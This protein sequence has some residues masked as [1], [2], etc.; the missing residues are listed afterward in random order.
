MKAVNIKWDTD[1]MSYKDCGLPR[2]AEIPDEVILSAGL[3]AADAEELEA[4]ECE[5]IGE[6]LSDEYGFCHMGFDIRF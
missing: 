1:G 3:D 5:A 2:S 6:W 4:K